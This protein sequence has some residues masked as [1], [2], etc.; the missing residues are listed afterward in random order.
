VEK[1]NE[2]LEYL[3]ELQRGGI[4]EEALQGEGTL[5]I[6]SVSGFQEIPVLHYYLTV[7]GGAEQMREVASTLL[8]RSIVPV[9][10]EWTVTLGIT[11]PTTA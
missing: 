1:E 10:R 2:V 3:V 5:I 11:P 6:V 4:L 7:R 9:G 8:E